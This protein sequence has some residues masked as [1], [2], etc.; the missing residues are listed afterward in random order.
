MKIVF[1]SRYQNTTERGAENFVKEL[2]SRLSKNYQVDIFFGKD[3]D[4]LRKV[5]NGNYD[6]VIPINGRL[7]S[8]KFSIGRLF[9]K[10]KLL[11]SGHSGQ[12][13]DDI[14]N[15]T[16]VRPD[17]FI[18]LTDS[19]L[20][21]AKSWAFGVKII[22]IS[23]GVDIEKFKPNGPKIKLD[24]GSPVILSV[25]ALSWYKH[26]ERVIN[27]VSKLNEGS[28]LIVGEGQEK[29]NL[30]KLG[31]D[32]LGK[33]FKITSYPFSEMPQVYRAVDLFTLPSWDRE[34]FGMVYLEALAS[35]LPVVAPDDLSRREILGETGIFTDVSDPEKYS[36]AI[37]TA[38]KNPYKEKSRMQAEKFSWDIIA[39]EYERVIFNII[40]K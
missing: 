13:R 9:K 1:L 32:K 21:W 14:W 24:L 31:N 10:Y 29:N 3:A 6:L 17:V 5:F 22:K 36:K 7:Q 15:I 8:L 38:L 20:S 26:H 11:I 23:D 12:G 33:N 37:Q 19:M 28:L 30:E 2:S 35:G 4:S 16:I 25:G 18:A 27:A 39:K 34:A 40:S